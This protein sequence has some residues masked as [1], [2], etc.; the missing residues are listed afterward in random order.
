[1][2]GYTLHPDVH[3]KDA[4]RTLLCLFAFDLLWFG[5]LSSYGA[6]RFRRM[7]YRIIALMVYLII[8]YSLTTGI[9]VGNYVA[10]IGWAASIGVLVWG[11]FNGVMINLTVQW[12]TDIAVQDTLAG[13]TNCIV[14]AAVGAKSYSVWYPAIVILGLLIFLTLYSISSATSTS[15]TFVPFAQIVQYEMSPVALMI[16]GKQV[17]VSQQENG[18]YWLVMLHDTRY[19]GDTFV[20]AVLH[21]FN[22]ADTGQHYTQVYDLKTKTVPAHITMATLRQT[23]SMRTLTVA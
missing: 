7:P 2:T 3:I 1:M 12:T 15:N 16:N 21:A 23:E 9:V 19:I 5:Y 18:K 17:V 20:N 6:I 11:V 10:S 14:A 22:T 4:A 13:V 8:A